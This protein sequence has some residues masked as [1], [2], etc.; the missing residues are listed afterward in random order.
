[1]AAVIRQVKES[2]RQMIAE[3]YNNSYKT[4]LEMGQKWAEKSVLSNTRAIFEGKHIVSIIQILPYEIWVGGKV[5]PMGGIG[6]VATRADSQGKGY[7]G[8]LM[9]D[10]VRDMREHKQWTSILYPFS[11]A[12]YR[13]FGWELCGH[14]LV[15][16]EFK[17]DAIRPF[18][19]K[20]LVRFCEPEKEIPLLDKI[21]TQYAKKYNLTVKRTKLLWTQKIDQI[22]KDKGQGYIIEDKSEGIGYM[23]CTHNRIEFGH[24]CMIKEFACL[25]LTAYKAFFG[26][27]QQM[28]NNISRF[29]IHTPSYPVLWKYLR[30]PFSCR[31]TSEPVF[32]FRVVDVQKA[33]ELRGYPEDAKGKITFSI[34]DDCGKWNEGPW[35]LELESGKAKLSKTS[36][37]PEFSCTIQTFSELYSGYRVA[38]DLTADGKLEISSL[39]KLPF[40]K[41]AFFDRTTHIMDY[42]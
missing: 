9:T 1:M 2:E 41:S 33:V 11:H 24:E 27:L 37:T 29:Q 40:L 31:I 39:S 30:E 21:Y 23:L 14:R 22:M 42:F 32:Q 17:Q 34:K 26:F 25:N 10:S 6:G 4:G 18:D 19:E 35:K 36:D 12:Y 5:I 7:A 28:P 8:A 13:K 15:F 38:D 20:K 3:I 16:R